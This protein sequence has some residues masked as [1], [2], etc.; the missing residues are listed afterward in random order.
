MAAVYKQATWRH[1]PWCPPLSRVLSFSLGTRSSPLFSPL[2]GPQHTSFPCTETPPGSRLRRGCGSL[3]PY[4]LPACSRNGIAF[5]LPQET[6]IHF[7][8]WTGIVNKRS[9]RQTRTT[10]TAPREALTQPAKAAALG[11]MDT[12]V[13]VRPPLWQPPEPP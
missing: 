13:P 4:C 8:S 11:H 1:A 6:S 2:S 12:D 7:S 3:G 10:Q 9:S 5:L